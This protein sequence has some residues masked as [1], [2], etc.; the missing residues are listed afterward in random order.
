VSGPGVVPEGKE[1][2]A[3]GGDILKVADPPGAVLGAG[4]RRAQGRIERFARVPRRRASPRR[5]RVGVAPLDACYLGPP[6]RRGLVLGYGGLAP[7]LI[8]KGAGIL[9]A[10]ISEQAERVVPT[11]SGAMIA[12][13]D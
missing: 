6:D 2:I 1:R 11:R 5:R 12:A 3:G 13:T 10:V 4:G 9:A 8:A 7:D